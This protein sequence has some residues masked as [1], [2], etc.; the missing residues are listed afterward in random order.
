[1]T[2]EKTESSPGRPRKRWRKTKWF[3]GIVLTYAAVT[4]VVGLSW[5]AYS[6]RK[7][8]EVLDPIIARGEPL[9][10]SDFAADPIPDDQNAAVLYQQ[11]IEGGVLKDANGQS[12]SEFDSDA[13]PW[14]WEYNEMLH[15]FT[16]EC[17][18]R[19][20]YA[21]EL[22]KLLGMAQ[23]AFVLCRTA[24]RFDKVDWGIDFSRK[25][26][27]ESGPPGLAYYR[28]I[29]SLLSLAAVEAHDSGR[30][31]DAVEYLR[32]VIALGDSLATVPTEVN[33]LVA[34]YTHANIKHSLEEILPSI[35]IGFAPSGVRPEDLRVLMSELMDVTSCHR[36]LTLALMGERSVCY[37]CC[38]SGLS[39][40]M[41][42]GRMDYRG[43]GGPYGCVS[44]SSTIAKL[45]FDSFIVPMLRIDAAR[46]IGHT[47]AY[48][49][50]SSV[51]TL[52]EFHR[53]IQQAQR[54]MEESFD[55]HLLLRL[56]SMLM[57]PSLDRMCD[58]HYV[59]LANRRMAGVALAV[60]MYQIDRGRQPDTLGD[61][62]PEYLAEVPQDPMDEPGIQIRYVNDPDI[63]RLY[64]VG[65]NGRDDGGFDDLDEHIKEPKDIL[66]FL[67]G[68]PNLPKEESNR[69]GSDGTDGGR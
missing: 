46:V 27:E 32:D 62:V 58:L 21:K 20:K 30:D 13:A 66:F 28:E 16:T 40:A 51:G 44:V 25:A 39:L 56:L 61:L 69:D 67:N 47:D 14:S 15:R 2:D 23:D 6:H 3:Y 22:G 65:M 36:G 34:M 43:D 42:M 37:D 45:S 68:R 38:Q 24:R 33:Y 64:S 31:D 1:M 12:P 60:R 5:S 59:A 7:F 63:P 57:T 9:A 4:I 50:A 53:G 49:R 55:S 41:P 52:P 19:R 8:R 54:D 10:W 11:A 18:V 35:K 29:A 26:Y 48:V 17:E